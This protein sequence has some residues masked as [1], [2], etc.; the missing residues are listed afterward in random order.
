MLGIITVQRPPSKVCLK[1]KRKNPNLEL[2]FVCLFCTSKITNFTRLLVYIAVK[3]KVS[4][5]LIIKIFCH[6][7]ENEK[8]RQQIKEH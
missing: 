2:C 6:A 1:K 7:I 3:N 5:S 8:D 4:N